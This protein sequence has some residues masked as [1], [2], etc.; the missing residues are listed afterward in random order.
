VFRGE[1]MR[2]VLTIALAATCGGCVTKEAV[3]FQAKPQQEALIR[4]GNPALVSRKN[5]SIVLIRPAARH[6]V[7][8]GRP[9]FVVGIH[10][11][12]KGPIEFRVAN[13]E[14]AQAVNQ[15]AV[16][17]KVITYEQ[18]VTEE[19]NRQIVAA[20]LT[21]VAAGASAA[22]A[23]Q[24]GYYS[25]N[26]TVHTPRGTYQAHTTGYSPTAAAI[27]QARVSAQNEVMIANTIETGQRNM[28]ML[29][30]SVIKDNTLLPGEWYGGQVHL[31]PP[32]SDAG[33]GRKTYTIAL[34]V[35]SERHDIEIVQEP[36]Q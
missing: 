5:N 26:T 8:G 31:Q 2:I 10:N 36:M 17:M 9:I 6:F 35:G 7:P 34:L 20:V 11:L 25:R 15:Q 28:A 12:G 14:A 23:S 24:A 32:S 21:G 4:D 22:A 29:E 13:I 3:R 18:L 16:D 19:R 30:Q 1:F 27:A 33:G